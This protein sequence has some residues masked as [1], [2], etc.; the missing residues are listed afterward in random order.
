MVSCEKN[1]NKSIVSKK[2]I[3]K[4]FLLSTFIQNNLQKFIKCLPNWIQIPAVNHF[5]SLYCHQGI[6]VSRMTT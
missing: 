3:Q 1:S 4:G 6:S 2:F 5:T